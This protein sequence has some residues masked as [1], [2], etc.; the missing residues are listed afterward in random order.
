MGVGVGVGPVGVGVTVGVEVAGGPSQFPVS[1]L[2]VA[3]GMKKPPISAQ[4]AGETSG[5]DAQPWGGASSQQLWGPV[6][7]GVGVGVGVTVGVGVPVRVGVPVGLGV[8]LGLAEGVAVRAR[9][10]RTLP[11]STPPWPTRCI[12][13]ISMEI[14]GVGSTW[15]S[16]S[17]VSPSW[18]GPVSDTNRR[19]SEKTGPEGPSH[20]SLK[21]SNEKPSG[22]CVTWAAAHLGSLLFE[23]EVQGLDSPR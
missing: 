8:G 3:P 14:S 11:R 9:V 21:N 10:S 18:R 5:P 7:V 2:H 22:T 1:R 15:I 4:S 12:S 13:T 20:S 6:G 23:K 19:P 17:F 16:N